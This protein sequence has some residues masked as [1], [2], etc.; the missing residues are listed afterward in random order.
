MTSGA[1][2]AAGTSVVTGGP[3]ASCCG[4]ASDLGGVAASSSRPLGLAAP[5]ADAG[6]DPVGVV[7]DSPAGEEGTGWG[8]DPPAGASPADTLGAGLSYTNRVGTRKTKRESKKFQERPLTQNRTTPIYLGHLGRP[9]FLPR[10]PGPLVV[11]PGRWRFL[12]DPGLPGWACSVVY[13]GLRD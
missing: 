4:A 3:V 6:G 5:G 8:P 13:G 12:S 11:V 7:A 10:T 2:A 1:V 9:L